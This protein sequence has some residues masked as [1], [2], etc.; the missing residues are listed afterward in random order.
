MC[1]YRILE[2]RSK[3]K[4]GKKEKVKS[5][6]RTTK[7]FILTLRKKEKQE[8]KKRKLGLSGIELLLYDI[9]KEKDIKSIEIY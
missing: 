8:E 2:E 4:R 6:I 5:G 9:H 7:R 1:V 3:K